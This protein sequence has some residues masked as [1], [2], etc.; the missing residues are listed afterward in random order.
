MKNTYSETNDQDLLKKR[1]QIKGLLIG[2]LIVYFFISCFLGY[3]FY[4]KE[5]EKINFATLLPVF[6]SPLTLLPLFINLKSINE[7][8]KNRKLK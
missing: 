7:E 1:N 8:I 5:F 4:T 3:L 2:I 6:I